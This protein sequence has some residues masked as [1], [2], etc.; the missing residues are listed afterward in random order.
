MLAE[1]LWCWIV[2]ARYDKTPVSTNFLEVV[3]TVQMAFCDGKIAK[4]VMWQTIILIPIWGGGFGG[5]GIVEVL[6]KT[7]PAFW[8]TALVWPFHFMA[9]YMASGTA[10]GWVPPPLRPICSSSW[11]LQVVVSL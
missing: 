4:E 1:N 8:A 5:I 3:D 7:V 10:V 6:W 2:E 11:W 9:C